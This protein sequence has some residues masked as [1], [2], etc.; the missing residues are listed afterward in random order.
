MTKPKVI[1]FGNGIL[2]DTVLNAISSRTEVI[3]HAKTKEDLTTAAELKRLHPEAHGIL[4]SFGILIKK[5]LLELFEPEG[6][7]NIHPS[8][9]PDLRGASPI[10]TA[11][12]RGDTVFHVSVMKLVAA[13][14]AGPI[15]YQTSA[16]LDKTTSKADIYQVLANAGADWL[17]AHLSEDAQSSSL[18][19]GLPQ[20]DAEATFCGKFTKDQS[21]L[22]PAE[23]TAE[24]LYDQI[25]AFQGFPKSRF[26]FFGTDCI[27]LAAHISNQPLNELSLLCQDGLYLC[28]DSLQPA[29]KRPMDAKSFLNGYRR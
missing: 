25:R 23:F 11:I 20:D 2:A 10:E 24:Q 21:Q 19:D 27:I 22:Q 4:A 16:E 6:I 28:I 17:V 18:P 26:T 7:L 15:Y 1:F 3:F 13:M 14:D 8:K 9:L 5:D 12:L 29:G